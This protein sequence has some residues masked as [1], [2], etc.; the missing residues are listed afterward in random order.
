MLR[1]VMPAELHFDNDAASAHNT[2]VTTPPP[3]PPGDVLLLQIEHATNHPGVLPRVPYMTPSDIDWDVRVYH[4]LMNIPGTRNL[5]N[6]DFESRLCRAHSSGK[7][8]DCKEGDGCKG[9][10]SLYE[11][12]FHVDNF[13]TRMCMFP[14]TRV[15]E[16]GILQCSRK[17]CAFAH[18]GGDLRNQDV[19]AKTTDLTVVQ[20]EHNHAVSLAYQRGAI[21]TR[22]R[23]KLQSL[24]ARGE[25]AVVETILNTD[26]CGGSSSGFCVRSRGS[27]IVVPSGC[28]QS[29]V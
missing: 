20:V 12:M 8:S 11:T 7:D 2:P 22:E 5:I 18:A 4:L 19:E 14:P 10:R 3:L 29:F 1:V 13:G 15:N 17:L 23:R 26:S 25:H 16:Y 28:I 24:V 21:D 9:A 6:G 27:M